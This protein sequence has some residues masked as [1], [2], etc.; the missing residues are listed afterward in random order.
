MVYVIHAE[1]AAALKNAVEIL[2]NKLLIVMILKKLLESFKLFTIH[3]THRE[4]AVSV[5]QI[6]N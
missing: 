1:K 6:K 2:S 4:V 5:A 3:V